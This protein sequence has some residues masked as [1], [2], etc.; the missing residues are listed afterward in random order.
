MKKALKL[1]GI[2]ALA[3]IMGFTM[4]ACSSDDDDVETPSP[5]N[6]TWFR[7]ADSITLI[8]SGNEW[9]RIASE[10]SKQKGVIILTNTTIK[11]NYTHNWNSGSYIPYTNN[12][13]LAG[14]FTV[15]SSSL[16]IS[17]INPAFDGTWT[18][19]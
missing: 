5:L 6:G 4:T 12:T 11:F 3:A 14:P 19:Q 7:T 17:D 18:K 1:L 2:I 9:E 13:L 8:I 16:V 10:T 15:T